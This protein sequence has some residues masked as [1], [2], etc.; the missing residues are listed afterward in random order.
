[1]PRAVRIV[2]LSRENAEFRWRVF[3]VVIVG[4]IVGG[5]SKNHTRVLGASLFIRWIT[6][7]M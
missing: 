2:A 1:M 7:S 4:A 5:E 6:S 3:V